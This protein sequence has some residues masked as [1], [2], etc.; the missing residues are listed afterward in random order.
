MISQQSCAIL[1]ILKRRFVLMVSPSLQ[2][3]NKNRQCQNCETAGRPV[4]NGTTKQKQN[5]SQVKIK[6]LI[7]VN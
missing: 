4:D 1:C 2:Q 6:K 5:N 3:L 7:P